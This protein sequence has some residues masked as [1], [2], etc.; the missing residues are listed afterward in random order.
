MPALRPVIVCVDDE[1]IIL[2]SLQEQILRR[3]GDR[4]D[5]EVAESPEEGLELIQDLI[6]EKREI[7]W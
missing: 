7:V 5:C 3:L 1:K 6:Q 2:D 4:F